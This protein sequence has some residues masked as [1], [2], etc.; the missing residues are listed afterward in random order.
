MPLDPPP[1]RLYGRSGTARSNEP[2]PGSRLRA[3]YDLFIASEGRR[4]VE[5]PEELYPGRSE[6]R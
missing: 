5:V 6:S 4:L 3:V 1:V 2:A